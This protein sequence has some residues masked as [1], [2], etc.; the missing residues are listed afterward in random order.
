MKCKAGSPA[1]D[2]FSTRGENT[3][4]SPLRFA[5]VEM[6]C[7]VVGGKHQIPSLHCGMEMQKGCGMEM[8]KAKEQDYV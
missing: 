4:V 7:V 8:Q 1:A 5:S 2:S 3:G 6:T